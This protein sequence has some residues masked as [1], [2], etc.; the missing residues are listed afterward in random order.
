MTTVPPAPPPPPQPP[1]PAAPAQ[2]VIVRVS[3]P[4]PALAQ[5]PPNSVLEG[6][7]VQAGG[8]GQAATIL[9]A[10][11]P[12]TVRAPLPLPQG[13]QVTL[14]LLSLTRGGALLRI[15]ALNGQPLGS[16]GSADIAAMR[17]G[18]GAAGA[19]PPGP[20]GP[21][22]PDPPAAGS[23]R[24]D[25]RGLITATVV[26]GGAPLT[27]AGA[28]L[29]AGALLR[30][31]LVGVQPPAGSPGGPA[32]GGGAIAG[33]AP[34][35]GAAGAGSPGVP[36]GGPASP[37]GAAGGWG[38]GSLAG[39]PGA[40]GAPSGPG[41]PGGTPAPATPSTGTP[42]GPGRGPAPADGAAAQARA[43]LGALVGRIGAALTVTP[44][45]PRPSGAAPAAGSGLPQPSP[46][47][48]PV[49][50]PATPS[51]AT[52]AP[53][54]VLTGTIQAG[55]AGNR[56]LVSTSAGTLALTLRLDAPAGSQVTLGVV[57]TTPQSATPAPA[58][59]P[60]SIPEGGA[61]GWPAL[62]QAVDTLARADPAAANALRQAI[63]QPGPR[64]ALA[65]GSLTAA[66]RA[67]GD[68]RQW[69]GAQPLTAL[70]SSGA[71]GERLAETLRGEMRA[72]AG[73]SRE[74]PGGEWRALTLPLSDGA[75]IAPITL[76]TR[77]RDGRVR[78]DDDG[79]TTLAP[80]R[81]D[82]PG[83]R[84]VV[85]LTLSN[86][87]RLQLDGL[88]RG[89]ARQLHLILRTAA[90]LPASMRED[91]LVIAETGM[92]ALGLEGGL[93]FQAD[94]RFVDPV[95][96]AATTPIPTAPIEGVI[97]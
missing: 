21:Q 70:E 79:E 51:T 45:S 1:S 6:Q 37:G 16:G 91:L 36:G 90:P 78:D 27:G 96:E 54:R 49:P 44:A 68:V 9:T 47:A 29:E 89:R 73:R 97:A 80:R 20:T 24:P 50:A 25:T 5:Q 28:A 18:M 52:G 48:T 26:R 33:G 69:P 59:M 32:Q 7:V 31:R 58:P 2:P 71:R 10:I 4:P 77:I 8:R 88:S 14:D 76:I 30:L 43:S 95:P 22:R 67:G 83:D 63:P 23:T 85:D 3:A 93:T 66:L 84:F 41:T 46:T 94:G 86:L 74:S 72:L 35:S 15:T 39:V 38:G 65:L 82:D 53:E 55:A 57:S 87:G 92:K 64:L 60:L 56:T 42:P 11:G 62:T 17:P 34:G 40:P 12:L 13:T 81:G 19:T 75:E 61:R